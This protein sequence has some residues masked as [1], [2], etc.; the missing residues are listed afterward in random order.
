[1]SERIGTKIRIE[2]KEGSQVV[3]VSGQPLDL[4][5]ELTALFCRN[6][7]LMYLFKSAIKFSE[8]IGKDAE[9]FKV[10]LKEKD[11]FKKA[12]FQPT[13]EGYAIIDEFFERYK[14]FYVKKS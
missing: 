11:A 2:C 1:M 4:L 6:E 12:G 3:E 14:E 13:A 5:T 10:D 9:F 7:E 8:V